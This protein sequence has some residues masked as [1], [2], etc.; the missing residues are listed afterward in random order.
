MFLDFAKM[1]SPV[2]DEK[3]FRAMFGGPSE[4]IG[5]VFDWIKQLNLSCRDF[6]PSSLL[7]AL[8]FLKDPGSSWT[9]C[10]SR[11]RIDYRTLKSHLIKS[12]R[13]LN[14]VLPEVI[15]FF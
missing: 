12:L 2:K 11:W 3:S 4:A 8:N 5:V 14:L 9:S 10:A 7:V 1:I 13:L 6:D 15:F